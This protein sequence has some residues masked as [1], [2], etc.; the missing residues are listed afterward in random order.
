M[1][2]SNQ[3]SS[4]VKTWVKSLNSQRIATCFRGGGPFGGYIYKAIGESQ[5]FR[6]L[7]SIF[8]MARKMAR[9]LIV[10]NPEKWPG[11]F[12]AGFTGDDRG[13]GAACPPVGVAWGKREPMAGTGYNW[14][15]YPWGGD[16]DGGG[17]TARS[18]LGPKAL[19][20]DSNDRMDLTA[21]PISYK[22]IVKG[23]SRHAASE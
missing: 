17:L 13:V 21:I 14:I 22:T 8:S 6:I 3:N 2:I 15:R 7:K 20:Y 16:G 11:H 12:R 4:H 19:G 1:K 10:Q 5:S 9:W 23:W 18:I